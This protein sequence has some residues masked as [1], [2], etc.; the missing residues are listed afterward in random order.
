M[1]RKRRN[2]SAGPVPGTKAI[3][4]GRVSTAEQVEGASLEAQEARLRAYATA[5]GLELV[6]VLREEAVS[7]SVPLAERPQGGEL[8]RLLAA[9]GATHVLAVKLDRLFRDAADALVQVRSWD[10]AGVAVHLLD[11]GG[12]AFNT[13]S[14]MG[15]VF[16]GMLASFA[17]FERN[18]IAERTSAA[19]QHKS[20]AGQHVGRPPTGT[21]IEA[22]RL[23]ADGDGLRLFRRARDLRQSGLTYQDVGTRLEAE[24]FRPIHGRRFW[25][26]SVRSLILNANLARLDAGRAA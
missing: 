14:A 15:R 16:L 9:H 1:V 20:A 8:V 7:G 13:G 2:G 5:Q 22:K 23:I 12:S 4:Y 19:L 24:G 6:A 26:S 10:A 25:G 18:V 11:M 17:E 21:R 3:A